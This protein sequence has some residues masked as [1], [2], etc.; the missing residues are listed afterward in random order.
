MCVG[1]FAEY[2]EDDYGN[3]YFDQED[4][5]DGGAFGKDGTIFSANIFLV[6]YCLIF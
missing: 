3:N 4:D 2:G 5:E 6:C 1:V